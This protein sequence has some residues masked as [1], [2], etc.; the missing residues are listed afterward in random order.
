LFE[1]KIDSLFC[2]RRVY[3]RQLRGGI[4]AMRLL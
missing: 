1:S 2:R 3:L 4:A